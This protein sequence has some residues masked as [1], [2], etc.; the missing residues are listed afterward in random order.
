MSAFQSA[1]TLLGGALSTR[2]ERFLVGRFLAIALAVGVIVAS[3]PVQTSLAGNLDRL[4]GAS[5]RVIRGD[6]GGSGAFV[7]ESG[8][9]GYVLT[10]YHVLTEGY[11]QTYVQTFS[12]RSADETYLAELVAYDRTADVALLAAYIGNDSIRTVPISPYRE[13]TDVF[14]GTYCGYSAGYRR[15]GQVTISQSNATQFITTDCQLKLGDSGSPLV[16][17][18]GYVVGVA[19]AKGKYSSYG[20]FARLQRVQNML[21][22]TGNGFVYNSSRSRSRN[23]YSS[24]IASLQRQIAE[25]ERQIAAYNR[26]IVPDNNVLYDGGYLTIDGGSLIIIEY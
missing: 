22:R 18:Q 10:A 15:H 6:S 7:K 3:L 25:L 24:R 11:G 19:V 21:D 2:V 12:G 20:F 16:N 13:T 26:V 1:K 4:Y 23:T 8:R 5:V 9:I 17:G 14:S